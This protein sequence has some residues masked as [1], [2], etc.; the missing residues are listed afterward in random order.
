[1]SSSCLR[2]GKTVVR[3]GGTRGRWPPLATAR[4]EASAW[5]LTHHHTWVPPGA[6]KTGPGETA[7]QVSHTS[8]CVCVCTCAGIFHTCPNMEG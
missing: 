2:F 8:V 5:G 4:S 7:R 1:M 6:V 3:P